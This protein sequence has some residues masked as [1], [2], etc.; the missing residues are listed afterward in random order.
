MLEIVFFLAVLLF[1]CQTIPPLRGQIADAGTR[2]TKSGET[3]R[4]S[5]Q[6]PS[7]PVPSPTASKSPS[8]EPSQDKRNKKEDHAESPNVLISKIPSISVDRDKF[9]YIGTLVNVVLA[10]IGIGGVL[11]ALRTLRAVEKQ[12]VLMET[13]A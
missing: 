10:L 13:Q 1:A 6:H 11:A 5:S 9:D 3:N 7:S 2:D 12:A 8:G 4:G